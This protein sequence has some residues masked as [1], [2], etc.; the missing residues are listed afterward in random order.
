MTQQADSQGDVP[1]GRLAPVVLAIALV[2]IVVEL[3]L[4]G[5]DRRMFGSPLWRSLAYQYGAFW[6]GL[7]HDWVPNYAAQPVAMFVSYAF[8]HS[9]LGHLAGNMVT[10][11]ALGEIAVERVGQRGFVLIY[12]ASALAGGACYGALTAAQ[13]MVGASGALFGLAGAWVVWS[14]FDA[15]PGRARLWALLRM[16]LGLT[17]LNIALW[18]ILDGALAWQTHLGGFVAGA[19][20]AL[21]LAR[22]G[23]SRT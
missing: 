4:V 9:G 23:R 17:G 21:L 20:M 15:A 19:V 2:C 8:L 14:Y 16:S 3:A 12:V 10:L 22:S 6:P 1:P 13:P 11:L 5:A 18:Y 7:L